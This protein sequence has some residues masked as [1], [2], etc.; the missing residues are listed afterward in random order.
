MIILEAHKEF[1]AI[2]HAMAEPSFY[3]HEVTHLQRL[4]THISTVFLTGR[5]VY[6]LKKP[7]DF[8]F[9]DF[10][11]LDSRRHFCEREVYL[12]QRLSQGVYIGVVHICRSRE[13]RYFI[14]GGG[15]PVEYAVKMRQLPEEDSLLWRI[16]A[17]NVSEKDMRE[18]GWRLADFYENSL[19]DPEID[20]YGHPDLISFNMEENFYQIRPFVDD[21]VDSEEYELIRQVNR[22]FFLYY[23]GL[24]EKRMDSG[25]IRDGHGDLRCDHVYFSQ[26]IQI[27][28]CIEFNDRF[29]YGDVVSDLA[30]LHMDLEHHGG[31]NLCQAFLAAYAERADDFEM[32]ALLDFYACYRAM[33]KVKVACL[34]S[35]ELESAE[36]REILKGEARGYL[37]GAY[38]YALQFSRPTIWVIMG[39]PATGKSSVAQ[40]ISERLSLPLFQSDLIR[41]EMTGRPKDQA[42][43]VPYGHG[44]YQSTLRQRVYAKMLSL[45]QEELK[46]GHSIVLDATFSKRR[47]RDEVRQL[48]DDLGTNLIVVECS[49]DEETIR[50]RLS[51]RKN[52]FSISDARLQHLPH[53]IADY[54]KPT[55][56]PAEQYFQVE[57]SLPSDE[58]IAEVFSEGYVKKRA[59]VKGLGLTGSRES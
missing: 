10:T 43:I 39:L 28:D 27:I 55:E 46:Q 8:G 35:A 5:W 23:S 40:V 4:D 15:E 54:E 42:E 19:R 33:V 26:G 57:S 13:G 12:N 31:E 52:E 14:G 1:E 2:C 34:R 44:A 29:R 45:A 58:M 30:F 22:A 11:K 51:G 18:L 36:E 17:G 24:F 47:W 38:R 53:M 56:M 59:Q 41:K 21:L 9:L 6:K 48:A 25:R 7:V 37:Q 20:Q 3:P 50:K 32:Y 49:C 16:A